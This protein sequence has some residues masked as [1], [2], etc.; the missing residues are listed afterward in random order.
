MADTAGEKVEKYYEPTYVTIGMDA[1]TDA[2][3]TYDD[4][5]AGAISTGDLLWNGFS[6][7]A[8]SGLE[9]VNKYT[10]KTW[11][12]SVAGSLSSSLPAGYRTTNLMGYQMFGNKYSAPMSGTATGTGVGATGSVAVASAFLLPSYWTS[13]NWTAMPLLLRE[14][15]LLNLHTV[16]TI[17]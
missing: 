3:H 4:A 1:I 12:S 7:P 15:C 9:N 13:G 6:T 16:L 5:S 8:F 10:T 11:V 14:Q 17:S 2:T